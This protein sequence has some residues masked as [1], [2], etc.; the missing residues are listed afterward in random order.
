[1]KLT[2]VSHA[3]LLV[4]HGG[5]QLV[6]DPWIVGSCYWRSWWN[7]PPAKAEAL[8]R[9]DPDWVYL[10]HIHW[11][12][13]HGPSLKRFRRNAQILVPYDCYTRM[14]EDLRQM[15]FE[16]IVEMRHGRP[17]R[18]ADGLSVTS[19]HFSPC[20]DSAAVIACDGVT[21][22]NANDA[23][24]MGGPLNQ[25]LRRHPRI[26]FALRSHSSA[27]TRLCHESY[28]E[29]TR[30]EE[31][32]ES[33]LRSFAAFMRRVQPRYAVPFASNHCY[34]HQDT[35][36]FNALVQTPQR[37]AEYFAGYK[38]QRPFAT[39][40]VVMT[41]GD[42]WDS[43]AGF[44]LAPSPYIEN[45][46]AMLEAYRQEKAP[47]LERYYAWEARLKVS[48]KIVQRHLEGFARAVPWL[49][50]RRF[51]NHPVFFE[52]VAGETRQ[53]FR[54]DLHGGAVREVDAATVPLQALRIVLPA[55][56]FAKAL[57]LNMFGHAGISKRVRYCA[58]RAEQPLLNTLE[59][60]LYWYEYEAVPLKKLARPRFL[61]S[62]LDRWREVVLY[63]RLA[64]GLSR[65]IG[66]REQEE[67]LLS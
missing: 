60:M 31:E 7:Y 14:V 61:V 21:I 52:V 63:A 22:L 36:R 40:L 48:E 47:T 66:L 64:F 62:Y 26:D 56:V 50:R 25:I 18:L 30:L 4:E 32:Q 23:K 43:Q 57:Q 20:T 13:F 29:E 44:S 28:G 46:A 19:Y 10:S 55:S 37:V 2:I 16:N 34:L 8:A 38:V 51:R 53:A 9:L 3:G 15:G 39:E 59:G 35:F 49:I 45:R 54:F 27:N 65:G 6:C 24:F 17:L 67:Q 5:Q 42:S 33:Y 58:T 11:D 1:M 41:S 12:H